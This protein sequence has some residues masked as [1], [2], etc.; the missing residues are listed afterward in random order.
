MRLNPFHCFSNAIDELYLLSCIC[1]LICRGLNSSYFILICFPYS[2][3]FPMNAV[4][5]LMGSEGRMMDSDSIYSGKKCSEI[6]SHVL[7]MDTNLYPYTRLD[8]QGYL[9]TFTLITLLSVCIK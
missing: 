5:R 4:E 7:V 2:S 9:L 3:V 8:V 6:M 1:I